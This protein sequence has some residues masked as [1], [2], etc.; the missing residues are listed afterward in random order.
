MSSAFDNLCGPGKP[1]KV[2]PPDAKEFAGLL[3]SGKAR[4]KDARREGL[5]L[6]SRFD[7]AYNAAHALRLAALRWR[8]Y[9][10]G[11]RY[12][13][14][15]PATGLFDVVKQLAITAGEL[16][17]LV[18]VL[19]GHRLEPLLEAFCLLLFAIVSALGEFAELLLLQC[20]DEFSVVLG[21][22]QVLFGE[23]FQMYLV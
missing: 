1:L 7:L 18:F 14:V 12:T 10:S 21:E 23:F 16:V 13:S 19:F 17:W 3:R 4:L 20:P 5:A 11:N 8:D 2:E 9:R 22:V 6:E 15:S